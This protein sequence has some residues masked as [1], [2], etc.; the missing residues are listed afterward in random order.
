MA[1]NDITW[2]CLIF[3]FLHFAST[4]SWRFERKQL[5]D[6]IMSRNYHDYQ[7]SKNVDKTMRP[8]GVSLKEGI[9]AEQEL[10]EDLSP[11]QGFG[12]N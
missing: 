11:I 7:F 5:I 4:L 3:G 6:K 1:M 9:R 8:D 2:L 12:M 10:A